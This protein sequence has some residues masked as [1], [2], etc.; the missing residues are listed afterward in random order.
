MAAL[1]S[2]QTDR[3]IQYV[4]LLFTFMS[5]IRCIC[6]AWLPIMKGNA[7]LKHW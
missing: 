6:L 7:K 1:P 2:A 3:Q 5:M 4:Y